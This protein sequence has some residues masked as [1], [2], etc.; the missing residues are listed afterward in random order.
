MDKPYN[1]QT[2]PAWY[3]IQCWCKRMQKLIDDVN[4]NSK[5]IK[6]E[7]EKEDEKPV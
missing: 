5:T 2:Q 1:P 7:A 4:W 3:R 6:K